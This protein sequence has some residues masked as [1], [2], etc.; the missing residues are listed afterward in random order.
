M[1]NN[2]T[3]MNHL[4]ARVISTALLAPTLAL[5]NFQSHAEETLQISPACGLPNYTKTSLAAEGTDARGFYPTFALGD[6]NEDGR[7]DTLVLVGGRAPDRF[8][9]VVKV[10]LQSIDGTLTKKA[11]YELPVGNSIL[12]FVTADFNE[13]GHLDLIADDLGIDLI[14]LFGNGDGTFRDPHYMG[15]NAPGFPV[16][17]DI[18]NDHH[19]DIIAG[20]LDGFVGVFLG[21][22]DGA[23]QPGATL[24]SLVR[25]ALPERYGQILVGD[26]NND[27]K[28]DLAV[29]SPL[30]SNTEVGTLDV[31][32]GNG[33]GTF[34]DPIRNENVAA[35]RGALADF[36]GDGILDYAGDR[37]APEQ[38][39][40]WIGQGDGHFTRSRSLNLEGFSPQIMKAADLN[41][42]GIPDLLVAAE[43]SFDFPAAALSIFLGKGDGT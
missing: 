4:T 10:F 27:G 34:K 15:L 42:D 36:N 35:W 28:V 2:L 14:I 26:L 16:A 33:D 37:Y 39:D 23:F 19:M 38:V 29:P 22:G 32:L 20:T 31:F 40:I 7:M 18:N 30:D 5:E 13:D 12:D 17:L 6:F 11:E 21:K 43:G 9:Y 8:P 3:T 25:A 1:Q 41:S 24:D